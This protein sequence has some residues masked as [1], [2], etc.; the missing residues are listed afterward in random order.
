MADLSSRAAKCT[1]EA[2]LTQ[3]RCAA[4]DIERGGMA[5]RIRRLRDPGRSMHL[6]RQRCYEAE[7]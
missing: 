6:M 1:K 3:D 4:P 5:A 7:L 2:A